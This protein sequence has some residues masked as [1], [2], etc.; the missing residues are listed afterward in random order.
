MNPDTGGPISIISVSNLETN[1]TFS[2]QTSATWPTLS[3]LIH[4]LRPASSRT[5]GHHMDC[6]TDD[7][8]E[9]PITAE[10]QVFAESIRN[11]PLRSLVVPSENYW[12]RESLERLLDDAYLGGEKLLKDLESPLEP[13]HQSGNEAA[14]A[15]YRRWVSARQRLLSLPVY[16]QYRLIR[17]TSTPEQPSFREMSMDEFERHMLGV[18]TGGN[19]HPSTK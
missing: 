9:V 2:F 13:L 16:K 6:L 11:T 4:S 5:T 3:D 17:K 8:L 18:M 19:L 14:E 12:D 10:A 1:S 15:L 7:S